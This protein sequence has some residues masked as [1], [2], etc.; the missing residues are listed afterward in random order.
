MFMGSFLEDP[1]K[2]EA[3][4]FSILETKKIETTAVRLER[5][6][7]NM[8]FL[9]PGLREKSS[10]M[11]QADFS[12][13]KPGTSYSVAVTSISSGAFSSP[14]SR[15]VIMNETVPGPP[16]S[17]SGES[18]GSTAIL[19]SWSV[20]S[21]PN[22]KILSYVIRYRELCPWPQT[23]FIQ[24]MTNT[25]SA[26]YLLNALTP[27]TAYEIQVAAKNSA[28]IGKFL[29]PVVLQTAETAPGPV[30]NLTTLIL[31]HTTIELI[32]H[33]PQQ[34]NGKITKFKIVIT[35]IRSGNVVVKTELQAE[36]ITYGKLPQCDDV[37]NSSLK[38]T[39]SP[40]TTLDSS[41]LSTSLSDS[42][43]TETTS[44][45]FV[46]ISFI[47]DQ[48]KPFTTYVCEV[49]AFTSDG[50]GRI[51]SHMVRTP[52]AVPEDPP[53]HLTVGNITATSFALSWDPPTIITGK[54]SY[55]IELYG[56]SGHMMDNSTGDLKI[57]LTNIRPFTSYEVYV[58]AETAAGAGPKSNITVTTPTD[59]PGA[60]LNLKVT[61]LDA[62][63][64]KVDWKRPK[65]PNGIITQYKLKV[66]HIITGVTVQSIILTGNAKAENDSTIVDAGMLN[67]S[68]M[69]TT[70]EKEAELPN[71]LYEGSAEMPFPW[72]T[73]LS[74]TASTN[75]L[76]TSTHSTM[77]ATRQRYAASSNSKTGLTS[78]VPTSP[79]TLPQS[80]LL[81]PQSSSRGD[82]KTTPQP[83]LADLITDGIPVANTAATQAATSLSLPSEFLLTKSDTLQRRARLN[84]RSVITV[85]ETGGTVW[86]S[87]SPS[88][89][90][91]SA[92]L[93]SL[94]NSFPNVTEVNASSYN[95]IDLSSEQLSYVVKHLMPDTEYAISMSAFTLV[96]EGPL[97][98]VTVRTHEQVPG[99]VQNASYQNITSTS[100]LLFWDPP[101]NPN[102]KITH[103]TVYAM[104][105]P[106]NEAIQIMTY[107]TNIIIP[108]LKKYTKYKVRIA[109]S[110]A[111][112]ESSL[113]DRD[114]IFVQ[115]LE[116]VPES[117][118][119]NVMHGNISA[120]QINL[121]W[122]PP[123]KPNGIIIY[124]EV[125]F[126]NSLGLFF[127]NSSTSNVLL[128]NLKPYTLY[129]ISVRAYT[130]HGHGNQ[131]SAVLSVQ[132]NQDVPGS[133]PYN[134]TYESISS[135]EV[136]ISWTPPIEANGIILFYTINYWNT[137][138]FLNSSSNST[139]SVLSNLRKYSQYWI[140][141]SASTVFGNG[142]MISDVLNL[143]TL[144]D[145]P[146]SAPENIT[147][148]TITSTEVEITF[149]P[150]IT[151]NGVILWYTIYLT[152]QNGTEQ[153]IL[154]T[155]LLKQNITGLKEYTRYIVVLSASTR[156]GEGVQ[157]QPVTILTGEG[158]PSSPPHSLLLKQLSDVSVKLSWKPPVEP[159][160]AILFYT[161]YIWS[162][163]MEN[164]INATETFVILDGLKNNYEYHAY[165]TANTRFGDGGVKS[166]NITFKTSEGSPSDPPGNISYIN[167]SSSSIQVFWTQP[168]K[169]NGIIKYFTIYYANSSGIFN[170]TITGFDEYNLKNA[171]LSAPLNN[172]AKF[173]QYLLW[174]TAST[175]LGDGN[176]SSEVISVYTDED[177]PEG[178]VHNLTYQNL[179]SMAINVSWFPPSKP[180][181]RVFY[182]VTLSSWDFQENQLFF[183][184]NE[185]NQLIEGLNKYTD[186]ILEVTPATA[187]GLSNNTTSQLNI[188]TDEDIP[189]TPPVITLL[190]NL[191]AT[192]V[193]LSWD[194]PQ[195]PN[196][197]IL[198]Y[199]VELSGPER[200]QSYSTYNTSFIFS[201]LVLFTPYNVSVSARTI[202]GVGPSAILVFYTDESEPSA[203][204]QNL[205]L[206][207]YTLD[208]VSLMWD[209]SPSPNGVVLLYGF[210]VVE[211]SSQY[212]VYQNVSG[213]HTEAV[214]F[215]FEPFKRYD[216]SV[217]AFTKCGNGNLFSNVI[218]FTSTESVPEIVQNFLCISNSWQ[219]VLVQWDP[220][221][222]PNGIITHY[223]V[224]VGGN[225]TEFAAG[226][227]VQTFRELQSNTTYMFHIKAAT[228]VGEGKEAICTADTLP[229]SAPS[230]PRNLELVD[231]QST[232]VTLRWTKPDDIP[233]YLQSYKITA[234][235]RSLSCPDWESMECIEREQLQYLDD[236]DEFLEITV[237]ALQKFRWYRFRVA[238]S[239]HAGYGS[240]SGWIS[241]QTLSG[242]PDAP[243]KN[244]TAIA[245]SNHSIEVIW[246]EPSVITGPTSYLIDVTSVDS[247]DYNK[248]IVRTAGEN[249]TVELSDLRPFTRYSVIVTAF[250]G[251][252]KTARVN[253]KPS[254]SVIVTTLEAL[255]KDPPKN[256][257]LQMIPDDVTKVRVTFL[258]P[259][260]PNGEIKFYQAV[261]HKEE[262]PN[263]LKVQNLTTTNV[264]QSIT[265]VIEG[266]KG[267]ST[268]NI[269]ILAVN[270]AGE[271]PGKQLKI[272]MDIKAPP[273]PSEKPVTARDKSGKLLVTSRSITIKMPVCYFTD[274][275][276][277]I[278]KIQIIV[279]E[280]AA[281]NDSN[282]TSWY[283]ANFNK[284][285]PYF[286]DDGFPNPTCTSGK[287][288]ADASEETYVIG[289][290]D[291]CMTPEYENKFCNGPL[292]PRKQYLF[293]FRATNIKG[294]CTDSVYSEPVRTLG[295]GSS[296]RIIILAAALCVI[297]LALLVAATYVFFTRIRQKQKEGGTYSPRD[298]EI[299]NTKFKLDQLITVAD[300]ELKNE[301]LTRYSSLFFRRKEIYVIQLLSYRKSLKPVNKKSFL[302]HVEDLCANN[303]LKFQEEFSELPK[304]VQDL[305]S[306]DAD[307]PWNRSK[308]RFSNIKPYNNNRVKLMHD[309][310][311][312][313]SDYVNAS[314]VSGYL[315]PNEFIATQG[316]LPG[317]VV[318]FW[319]MIWET[320]SKTIAMLTQ[321]FEKGR[322]RCHQYWPEDNKPVAVFGDIVITKLAEDFQDDWTI[323]E[324]KIEKH[325]DY[326][327][328]RHFNFTS[329]PEHGVP[330]S[331][332]A[333]VRFVKLVRANRANDNTPIVV[334]CSAGVGRT[335]V[336]IAL[337]HLVQHINDHDFV[338]IYGLVAELRRERMCLVQNL[339]QYIFLHQC[340]A[341]LLTSRGSSQPLWFVNYSALQKM[342][343]LDAMEG[344]VELEW[345]ETTM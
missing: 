290:D 298:A 256:V 63:S 278:K 143:T 266:L 232:N 110:T 78:S 75:L 25:D 132:T 123:D 329:W 197:V 108:D 221:L 202:K 101:A 139:D 161:V 159:N 172:L 130:R 279:T 295:E 306:S 23:N 285:R 302:Q 31:N 167:I 299:I 107:N 116:D 209:P 177:V 325:G 39:S 142:N 227:H 222:R 219:S 193:E 171:S 312:P 194:P 237:Y 230:A 257:T 153:H 49:S 335:G 62:S 87:L 52:E 144:D 169:P 250:T 307:L 214:L 289:A 17:L 149:L 253:G 57:M 263:D 45:R 220:P 210:R 319:R 128:S 179:S 243:P 146:D 323:R 337:D 182:H 71:D 20:P 254:T 140:T 56:P 127:I 5:I 66:L 321:C 215:G 114:D 148:R 191:T 262:D 160:G 187:K 79:G 100:I 26:E 308:N 185:T 265:A 111:A 226:S 275:H 341:D 217:S 64:I 326:M 320:R 200:N 136:F 131:T 73:P 150:P 37:A 303:N 291:T 54:F 206:V 154:N 231:I 11:D 208:S 333:L 211:Y 72:Q 180:N 267:G 318:D 29:D 41:S 9:I 245:K 174:I 165:V 168:S 117:P 304:L 152:M 183:I 33:L 164:M 315:C 80:S 135:T 196:G 18:I 234:E 42:A 334:H 104:E 274:D 14:V 141:V 216:I 92:S 178:P 314:Y 241:V 331:S 309:A 96:G 277:P 273:Q 218:R 255:P 272:T 97:T 44:I 173:S 119:K 147:Y 324:L 121:K 242:Y 77:D 34:P 83:L 317:T 36:D 69:P 223:M 235:L 106:T 95:V 282:I 252:I 27:G 224:T 120:T 240:P 24:V 213:F 91:P 247:E 313:G 51:A 332:S 264:D 301:K 249:N 6:I 85:V 201:D 322:I 343:S 21:N 3:H 311:V 288:R 145:V 68:S 50:E 292:K 98:S 344:D 102:G 84:K 294:Q 16:E 228:S 212:V 158:A 74:S 55:K 258:P 189:E 122:L 82:S 181:G 281:Q 239:T 195:Q 260:E 93:R 90:Q 276:G 175:A 61:E 105:V 88:P 246:K 330:E 205:T 19:V 188:K 126:E 76:Y 316:P 10:Y 166:A 284:T 4:C 35:H 67:A 283:E 151:P 156:K 94:V 310:V 28:G 184:T 233:G 270:G 296:E 103:Y 340:A 229:E 207:N 138:H 238:A 203:P 269:S 125:M 7:L 124:Y 176:Q 261:I 30:V 118:P 43:A 293:K 112:G 198:S 133:P 86:A 199:N 190:R 280:E 286:V 134:L 336:F 13:T 113:S 248:T 115:T 47:V 300:L 338:D 53:Q 342:D 46:P 8:Q 204:P 297:S 137:S 58:S 38:S 327:I 48:L 99:S 163:T 251:D 192:S 1:T 157:S 244:V 70:T 236:D 305:A 186:Y 109:A 81:L 12:S 32:W 225:T 40:F 170:Q 345:E 259:S 162:A 268:Y 129:N 89:S 287:G 22:G 339:A 60:V 271:G 2:H 15:I 65:Y 155:T 59:V 328:I